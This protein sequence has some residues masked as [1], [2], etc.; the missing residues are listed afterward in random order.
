MI[1]FGSTKNNLQI[2][3][4]CLEKMNIS[5]NDN[6]KHLSEQLT[7][8]NLRAGD[9]HIFLPLISFILVDYS[10]ELYLTILDIEPTLNHLPDKKFLIKVMILA[11][12]FFSMNNVCLEPDEFLSNKYFDKK[13]EFVANLAKSAI[14]KAESLKKGKA[15]DVFEKPKYNN[16]NNHNF[17]LEDE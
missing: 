8:Q 2:L 1:S 10:P 3:K 6:F 14:E 16:N 15:K 5:Q 17:D 12:E 7:E 4:N 13:L 9:N 11:R